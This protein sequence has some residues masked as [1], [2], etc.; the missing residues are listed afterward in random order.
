[1]F[2]C[3]RSSS[4]VLCIK[5]EEFIM[6]IYDD[7]SLCFLSI[8]CSILISI[9]MVQT[10]VLIH[11]CIFAYNTTIS[12]RA[13][14][15]IDINHNVLELISSSGQANKLTVNITIFSIAQ[16]SNTLFDINTRGRLQRFYMKNKIVKSIGINKKNKK[17]N[18]IIVQ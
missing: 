14:S 9:K 3:V 4:L 11:T 7:V 5:H 18:T 12:S 2:I 17:F 8:L 1:M 15:V 10:H 13:Q 6:C 16:E